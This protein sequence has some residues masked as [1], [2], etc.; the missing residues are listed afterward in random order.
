MK[1]E[2]QTYNH[3]PL[4]AAIMA[5]LPSTIGGH[6]ALYHRDKHRRHSG[7]NLRQLNLSKDQRW[8]TTKIHCYKRHV[9]SSDYQGAGEVDV[10]D[11][12]ERTIPG[13]SL[14]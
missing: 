2:R 5:P 6:D 9:V 13:R 4:E 7:A 11:V 14:E 8:Y 1:E 3:E 10:L 12:K